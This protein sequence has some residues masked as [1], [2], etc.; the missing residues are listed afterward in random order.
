[1]A[2]RSQKPTVRI[3]ASPG[4]VPYDKIT[5]IR[6][7]FAGLLLVLVVFCLYTII[8]ELPST[9]LRILF[10]SPNTLLM[11]PP[12]SALFVGIFSSLA[13]YMLIKGRNIGKYA[14]IVASIFIGILLWFAFIW[15]SAFTTTHM[16]IGLFGVAQ[17]CTEVAYFQ[18]YVLFLNPFALYIYTLL[19]IVGIAILLRRLQKQ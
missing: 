17:S 14:A 8:T 16:C 4:N 7:S 19:S 5:Y 11:Y 2:R 3:K 1:M 9:P 13:C 12:I 10:T 15:M 6:G 18:A